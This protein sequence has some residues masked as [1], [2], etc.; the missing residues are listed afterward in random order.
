VWS[1]VIIRTSIPALRATRTA[2]LASVRSGVH[3]PDER[4]ED[5]ICDRSHRIGQ[6]RGHRRVVKVTGG[7]R[8]YPQPALG[9]LAVCGQDLVPHGGDRHLLAMPQRPAA[10]FHHHVGRALD[11]DQVGLLQDPASQP[12]GAVVEGGHELVLRIKRHLGPAGQGVTCL[13]GVGAHL[14]GEYHEG[15]LRRVADD[16]LVVADGG[17]GAQRQALGQAAEVRQLAS[18]YPQDRAGLLVA[19]TLDLEP[20]TAGQ[21]RGRRH[22]VHGQRAGLV[23]V[24]KG[25]PAQGFHVGERLD[26]RFRVGQTP[27]P[28]RQHGLHERRQA[29]GDGRD[30]GRNAQQHQGRGV[31]TPHEA[32]DG[33]HG[34]GEEG[35]QPEYLGHA[36][37]FALQWRARPFGGR[38]HA[39][40]LAHLGRLAGGGHHGRRRPAGD[41]RVLEHQ[42]RP[43]AKRD[44]TLGESHPVLGYR[45]A[46]T[47][48]CSLLHL[49]GGGG[50][51]PPVRRDDVTGLQQ[52]HITGHKPG[53]FDLLD[54]AGPPY[55][56]PGHLQLC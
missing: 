15:R 35:D 6:G 3:D 4:D 55:P 40:D 9:Q 52:H 26:H 45:C 11:A 25:R 19:G 12:V 14:R 24:D 41:L 48:Q 8:E 33:D 46:L 13:Y 18:G 32:E 49:Q 36:V 17:I 43:V 29:G 42:I 27:C 39:G 2:S 28:R 34:H 47:G 50:D 23:A 16:R 53:R 5:Q 38:Y 44:L 37:E 7:E 10:A 56:S 54:L 31:L 30:R 1:P 21:H 22:R 51:D 20:F